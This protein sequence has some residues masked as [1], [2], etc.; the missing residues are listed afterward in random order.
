MYMNNKERL[1]F[2]GLL[3]PLQRH[4]ELIVVLQVAMATDQ[5]R[6]MS[7]GGAGSLIGHRPSRMW[8]ETAMGTWTVCLSH[9]A[10]LGVSQASKGRT[11]SI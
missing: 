7:F 8:V 3:G 10:S 2:L 11:N 9:R 6:T 4:G 1:I 5:W